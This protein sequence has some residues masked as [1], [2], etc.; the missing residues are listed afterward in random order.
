MLGRFARVREE[1]VAVVGRQQHQH[2]GGLTHTL[3]GSLTHLAVL[4]HALMPAAMHRFLTDCSWVPSFSLLGLSVREDLDQWERHGNILGFT[5]PHADQFCQKQ[6]AFIMLPSTHSQDRATEVCHNLGGS[7]VRPNTPEEDSNLQT[8]FSQ[9]VAP[10]TNNYGSWVWVDAFKKFTDVGLWR[11]VWKTI[12]KVKK[13]QCLSLSVTENNTWV[14]TPCVEKLCAVCHAVSRPKLTLRGGCRLPRDRQYTFTYDNDG[15]PSLR[16]VQGVLIVWD[17]DR[18]VIEALGETNS[19]ALQDTRRSFDT[20][21]LGVTKWRFSAVEKNCL[22]ETQLLLSV[23]DL[24]HFACSDGL[25]CVPWTARC[26]LLL[27][28]SDGSDEKDCQVKSVSTTGQAHVPP[29]PLPGQTA[30]PIT[31]NLHTATMKS[32]DLTT[33]GIVVEVS[34]LLSWE[35][36]RVTLYNLRP[37]ENTVSDAPGV[38]TLRVGG[39]FTGPAA[40]NI[41]TVHTTITATRPHDTPRGS[42]LSQGETSE[43]QLLSCLVSYN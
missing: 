40:T 17:K 27:D 35:D 11:T 37:G 22:Q 24:D 18:W 6:E 28:C 30:V 1:G 9:Y 43:R 31:M 3:R 10:C 8:R 29:P 33:S 2:D 19:M 14:E 16:S 34:L 25:T 12:P 5:E 36:P 42:L 41:T 13:H 15:H 26:D 38:W 21:P 7:L 23:C 39:A 32:M 4:G 20:L